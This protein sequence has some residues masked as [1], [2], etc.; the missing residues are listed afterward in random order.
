[1]P[2]TFVLFEAVATSKMRSDSDESG[3][4]A[5]RFVRVGHRQHGGVPGI[6]RRLCSNLGEHAVIYL[7]ALITALLFV[8]LG[9]ALVRPEWF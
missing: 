5:A 8:Y 1:M 6:R 3:L 2:V 4:L 9:T 7:T